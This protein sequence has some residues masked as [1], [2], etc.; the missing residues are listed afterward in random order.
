MGKKKA[1]RER[2]RKMIWRRSSLFEESKSRSSLP[3]IR[4][5]VYSEYSR[6]A[7]GKWW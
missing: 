7:E 2:E 5:N 1:E 3:H 4:I 6:G